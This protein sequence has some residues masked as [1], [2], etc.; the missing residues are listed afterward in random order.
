MRLSNNIT[1]LTISTQMKKTNRFATA[2]S[3]KLS[4]GTKING[5]KD[6]PAGLAIINR[7]SAKIEI[8]RKNSENY[9]DGIS[10]L[11]TV[12]SAANG[13]GDML[14]RIRELAVNAA[15]GTL[16]NSDREKIQMEVSQ[17]KEQ[18]N[19]MSKDSSFNGINFL[20]GDSTRLSYPTNNNAVNYTY[21]SGN[22]PE[23]NLKYTVDNYG[24]PANAAVNFTTLENN[25][26]NTVTER[27]TIDLNGYVIDIEIGET[28]GDVL[29]KIKVACDSTNVMYFNDK[30]I[31]E[32]EGTDAQINFTVSPSTLSG[33]LGLNDAT[34]V[35][36][37]AKITFD[38]LY[39]TDAAGKPI[40]SFNSGLSVQVNGNDVSFVGTNNQQI[41]MTLDFSVEVNGDYSYGGVVSAASPTFTE[42]SKILNSGQLKIQAG[43]DKASAISLYF[44]KIDL[45][46]LRIADVNLS[47]A[48]GAT[49]AL[50]QIDKAINSLL[51]YRAE[52]GAYQ[53]RLETA[54]SS[55]DDATVNMETF[56][57]TIRDTDVAYEMSYYSNQNVKMQAAISVLAQANQ[58]PQQI[59]QLLG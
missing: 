54:A 4:S 18:I 25:L 8:S 46:T 37:D 3:L 2:S 42:S 40:P 34:A 23:G 33:A 30:L 56:M 57:S 13:I 1:A 52:I 49:K 36:I 32:D 9:Q 28:Y 39:T 41:D 27:G 44:R 50:T 5:A 53:N 19:K 48:D 31:T 59:L 14:Q 47:S 7:L 24:E 29:D 10:L 22:V 11:E 58:R 51:S 38:G 35:G 45:D 55:L 43:D 16:T 12:D 26:T 21:I 17:L 6:D 20:N 15:T